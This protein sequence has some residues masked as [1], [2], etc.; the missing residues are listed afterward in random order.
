LG[1]LNAEEKKKILSLNEEDKFLF[2]I[3]NNIVND[4]HTQFPQ[5]NKSYITEVLNG[6][7]MNFERSYL[8]LSDPSGHSNLLFNN[9]EDNLIL[10]MKGKPEF[11]NLE[12]EKGSDIVQEREDY[13]MG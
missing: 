13:L 6:T 1:S 2:K 3:L 12:K 11:S 8:I 5:Y 7:S 4:L 10:N 9:A